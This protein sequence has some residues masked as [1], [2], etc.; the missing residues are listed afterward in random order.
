MNNIVRIEKVVD[1]KDC[2]HQEV[3]KKMDEYR[4]MFNVFEASLSAETLELMNFSCT[5]T[6]N[7][8]IGNGEEVK[9][10]LS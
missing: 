8:F 7:D 6:C 5:Y 1:C 9:V 2:G 3:C 4:E 10:N